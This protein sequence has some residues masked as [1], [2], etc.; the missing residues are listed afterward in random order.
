MLRYIGRRLL[1]SIFVLFAV[2]V[3]S[4]SLMH[5]ADGSP[6]RLMVPDGASEEVIAA[7]EHEM[8]LDQPLYIQ[9][10]NYMKDVLHGDLGTSIQYKLPNSQIIAE[11]LPNSAALT[12]GTVLIGCPLCIPLGI[13]AGSN[14]GK[15]ADFF[16]MFFALLGNSMSAVWLGVLNVF[17]F[18]VWLGVLPSRGTGGIEYAILPA[19]TL[20]YPMAAEI[21]R[22][23]RSGMIDA[24]GEDYITAT[25]A[26]GISRT[27]VNWKYAFKNALIPVITLIGVSI[28]FYM[29]GAVVVETI[30]GW[31]GIGQL[32]NQAVGNRDYTLV[33][34]I[35][36][37]SAALFTLINLVVDIINS[38]IDPRVSLE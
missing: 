6:A 25:Y 33:Q 13:I 26:K 30:F 28:G 19:L 2:S 34:S 23:G 16:A 35:L 4:F 22:V 21:T 29:A 9:Y 31:P 5:M 3:F 7:V 11:R 18:S 37:I 14:R 32:I 10:I 1:Q 8:G 15:P 17:I 36:L 20:G 27:M 24:L 38:F 12:L